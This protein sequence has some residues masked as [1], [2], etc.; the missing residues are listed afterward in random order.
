MRIKGLTWRCTGRQFRCVLFPPMGSNDVAERCLTFHSIFL[1]NRGDK[2]IIEGIFFIIISKW[3]SGYNVGIV[4][5]K[6]MIWLLNDTT[7][8]M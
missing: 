8:K 4:L 5:R 2:M 1:N 7:H 3:A 6:V